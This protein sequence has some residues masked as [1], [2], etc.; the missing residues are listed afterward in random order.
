[1]PGG[2]A[3]G[4]VDERRGELDDPLEQLPLRE[5]PRAHPRRLEQLVGEE[6][7]TRFA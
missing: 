2:V 4:V 7:V 1:M 6:E 5:V 3:T